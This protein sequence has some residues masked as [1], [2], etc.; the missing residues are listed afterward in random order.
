MYDKYWNKGNK[1][2][3]EAFLGATAKKDD[4]P[5]KPAASTLLDKV[6][7]PESSER[8]WRGGVMKRV[9]SQLRE[10][11]AA[12]PVAPQ[13]H[14][15]PRPLA[16][17][18]SLSGRP[19]A[20]SITPLSRA[21]LSAA[22]TAAPSPAGAID[23]AAREA[24]MLRKMEALKKLAA[25]AV[26]PGA[27]AHTV[28]TPVPVPVPVP[29]PAAVA[30]PA[31]SKPRSSSGGAMM[32][33]APQKKRTALVSSSTAVKPGPGSDAQNAD[34]PFVLDVE[35]AGEGAR[36]EGQGSFDRL[37]V[38]AKSYPGYP[39]HD[40]LSRIT[41]SSGGIKK[42]LIE[43]GEAAVW[44]VTPCGAYESLAD[45]ARNHPLL[46][47]ED[48]VAERL[49]R[50]RARA[51]EGET[52][53]RNA[54]AAAARAGVSLPRDV[55]EEVEAAREEG[56][57][58]GKNGRGNGG[59][60]G[61]RGWRGARGARG[62]RGFG[63]RGYEPAAEEEKPPRFGSAAWERAPSADD[64]RVGGMNERELASA[65]V[66]GM[67]TMPG[68]KISPATAAAEDLLRLLR[69]VQRTHAVS[70]GVPA[71]EA[72]R[73]GDD[74]RLL[75][76]VSRAARRCGF[77]A[78]F[79]ARGA[80]L[81]TASKGSSS[82]GEKSAA[83]ATTTTTTTPARSK[84]P[85]P[86]IVDLSSPGASI[87]LTDVR[88]WDAEDGGGWDDGD[89]YEDDGP[90]DLISDD[91]DE[92]IAP[93]EAASPN[94]ES[95]RLAA[96]ARADAE[97]KA[98]A[99]AEWAAGKKAAA[100]AAEAR[101]ASAGPSASVLEFLQGLDPDARVATIAEVRLAATELAEAR[102]ELRRLEAV[103]RP[104]VKRKRATGP[105]EPTFANDGGFGFDL[106][107]GAGFGWEGQ[108]A[109]SMGLNVETFGRW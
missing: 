84:S 100:E 4:A 5:R 95:M 26:A 108:G 34:Q 31:V 71:N 15:P 14:P 98:K 83:T 59:G 99:E 60:R 55:G 23:D 21:P 65:L 40:V 38:R 13:A 16:P 58:L 29:V 62:G 47:L 12:I 36:G 49:R 32:S 35:L 46:A 81:A 2:I 7:G 66:I 92:D 97:R 107:T 41:A 104:T 9:G 51:E 3:S 78:D 8:K 67:K 90:I 19:I 91:E 22:T 63:S 105:R 109:A 10:N 33:F 86:D 43:K 37:T 28:P 57:K 11:P 56:N 103:L 1:R 54:E 79:F 89:G 102:R 18:T 85:E 96:V 61:G 93:A 74:P 6:L 24:M 42:L 50:L 53:L 76:I 101:A 45:R 80:A 48:L 88:G 30:P 82:F 25:K 39:A 17:T 75:P 106:G 27:P 70:L 69:F 87:D 64:E 73:G 52:R 68:A 72:A 44:Q 94:L 77:P 20:S